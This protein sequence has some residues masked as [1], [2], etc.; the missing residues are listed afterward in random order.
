MIRMIYICVFDHIFIAYID[1]FGTKMF[2]GTFSVDLKYFEFTIMQFGVVG[3][4]ETVSISK[5]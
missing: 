2:A 4:L 5:N 3:R 1:I